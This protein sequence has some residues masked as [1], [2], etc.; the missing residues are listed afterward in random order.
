MERDIRAAVAEG[1]TSVVT[2]LVGDDELIR[3]N[4]LRKAL[5]AGDSLVEEVLTNA[6]RIIGLACQSVRHLV[7]PDVIVIGGGVIEACGPFMMPIVIETV[8][9]DPLPGVREGGGVVQAQLGDDATLL[10]AVA[11]A[12]GF[13]HKRA[14]RA[15]ELPP[16]RYPKIKYVTWGEVAVGK[17]T[18]NGDIYIRAD[19]KVRGR[20][21]K[22]AKEAYGTSHKLGSQEL[23]KICKVRPEVLIIGTGKSGMLR[24]EPDGAK[25]LEERGIRVELRPSAEVAKVYNRTRGRKAALI[26]VTC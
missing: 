15:G 14:V 12:R 23:K 4:V 25:F 5:D 18:F 11:L 1:R 24:L 19:A 21:K 2:K 7:D 16:V 10:G 13:G 6:S 8:H 20:K 9:S 17:D 22:I 3:A 26:H